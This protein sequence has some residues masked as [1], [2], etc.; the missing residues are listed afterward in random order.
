LGQIKLTI[1]I[2]TDRNNAKNWLLPVLYRV[3]HGRADVK[4][5]RKVI[6]DDAS[7]AADLSPTVDKKAAPSEHLVRPER[8]QPNHVRVAFMRS[9]VVQPLGKRSEGVSPAVHMGGERI[10][11]QQRI[12]GAW[13]LCAGAPTRARI[14]IHDYPPDPTAKGTLSDIV[15]QVRRHDR[16][17]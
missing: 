4:D 10:I 5:L 9:H 2:G 17:P 3:R 14:A 8:M 7:V 6:W 16:P 15:R 12:H 11:R 1:E 13:S